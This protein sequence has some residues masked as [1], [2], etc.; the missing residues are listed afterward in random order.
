M[1]SFISTILTD[2]SFTMQKNNN[3]IDLSLLEYCERRFDEMWQYISKIGSCASDGDGNTV[4]ESDSC[5]SD[6]DGNITVE[7]TTLNGNTL[8]LKVTRGTSVGTLKERFMYKTGFATYRQQLYDID[9]GE[10]VYDTLELK[11]NSNLTVVLLSSSLG[12]YTREYPTKYENTT[13]VIDDKGRRLFVSSYYE[14]ACVNM[15][16]GKEVWKYS[17]NG[18]ITATPML[19]NDNKRVIW[20]SYDGKMRCFKTDTGNL[21]WTY[22]TGEHI[23]STS[24]LTANGRSVLVVSFKSNTGHL[25]CID[26]DT[27]DNLWGSSYF[28]QGRKLWT[29]YIGNCTLSSPTLT[30]IDN[31]EYALVGSYDGY[32][33][34]GNVNT[35]FGL[36][37]CEIIDTPSPIQSII[38]VD[39]AHVLVVFDTKLICVKVTKTKG[40]VLWVYDAREGYLRIPTMTANKKYVFVVN[41]CSDELHCL[42]ISDVK[43]EPI[44]SWTYSTNNEISSNPALTSDDKF[45]LVGC[46]NGNLHYVDANT[47]KC[48]LVNKYSDGEDVD[49]YTYISDITTTPGL[50]IAQMRGKIVY[51]SV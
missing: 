12:E 8:S 32:L 7:V 33:H 47:G 25:H 1:G 19:T 26:V 2:S 30:F 14:V 50:A 16:S 17:T 6:G 43:K 40:K 27:G 5:A 51:I 24:K 10:P 37:M 23:H 48:V 28:I 41:I 3:D 22:D 35:G 34:C 49:G 20:N 9:S 29:N 4:E 18:V 39:R 31:T 36:W 45:V 38:A 13:P 44:N 21:L 42:N 15:D 46:D 11:Q